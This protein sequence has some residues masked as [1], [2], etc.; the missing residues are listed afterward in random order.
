MLTVIV[1]VKQI[2]DPEAPLSLFKLSE[3][4]KLIPPPG[5][6][7]VLSPFDENALEAAL[8]LKQSQQTKITVVSMGSNLA[9]PV[10]RKVLSVGADELILLDDERFED[11]DCHNTA[12]VLA[13]AIGQIGLPDL[14]FCGRQ[15]ADT[16]A[17]QVGIGIAEILQIPAVTLA[18]KIEVRGDKVIVDR[19]LDNGSE[20][21]ESSMPALITVSQEI[22]TLRSPTLKDIMAAKK[23]E[24]TVRNAADLGISA[25][26][27]NQT[28]LLN[29]FIPKQSKS[30][31]MIVGSG[32]ED[33]A[34]GLTTVL[35]TKLGSR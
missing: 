8:R 23:M 12:Y 27:F 22:G 34:E 24:I 20:L 10:L 14:I 21:V 13:K 19:S 2:Y 32:P 28:M 16:D 1:C 15:A 31:Q 26:E 30:C 17:G 4:G 35:L 29:M 9:K 6:P 18:R 11:L 3:E 7:P 33:I 25:P 5:T